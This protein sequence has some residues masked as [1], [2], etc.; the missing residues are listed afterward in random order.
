MGP[1]GTVTRVPGSAGPPGIRRH[2]MIET[3][4]MAIDAAVR[5]PVFFGAC[6]A[7]MLW[8]A[9]APRRLTVRETIRTRWRVNITLFLVNAT[10]L[11]LLLPGLAVAAAVLA[12]DRQIGV[13]AWVDSPYW[14][15]FVVTV[16]VLDFVRYGYHRLMHEVP[17][18]WRLH[19][20]HHS[21]PEYDVTTGFRF[22]PGEALLGTGLGLLTIL[23]L[24]G[25]VIAVLVSEIWATVTSMFTHANGRLPPAVESLVRRVLVTPDLHRIHHSIRRE[26]A[27]SNFGNSFVVWDR[28]FGTLRAQPI[29]GH[30]GMTIGHPDYRTPDRLRLRSLLEDPLRP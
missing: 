23:A 8:E 22:H 6:A 9:A 28:L 15:S 5:T 7:M 24:G 3:T 13:F 27:S 29:D 21:D 25:P 1:G 18:L 4:A 19:R 2:A 10:L 30:D 26:E 16:L 11:N 17:L 14:L 12:V 20:S